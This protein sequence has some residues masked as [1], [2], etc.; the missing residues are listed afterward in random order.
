MNAQQA[1]SPA[2]AHAVR[3]SASHTACATAQRNSGGS[4]TANKATISTV[5]TAFIRVPNSA[6]S[7]GWRSVTS[8]SLQREATVPGVH[9]RRGNQVDPQEH[10]QHQR[11]DLDGAAG[12]V[13]HGA[14]ENL[15]D[16]G[17]SDR[18]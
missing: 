15:Q 4:V 17:I 10:A 2:A 12:L 8:A 1:P 9:D 14:G 5:M 7:S 6:R 3:L 18:G 16:L 13:E 11:H